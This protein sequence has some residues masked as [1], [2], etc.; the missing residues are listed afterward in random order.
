EVARAEADAAN[1]M[2]DQ[3]LA[4]LSH[5][6]RTPLSAMLGW[7]QMLRKRQVPP[8]R[9]QHALDV[10]HRNT[11]LQA[12]L[13]DDLLDIARVEAGKLHLDKQPVQL[14]PLIEDVIDALQRDVTA[15]QLTLGRHLDPAAG[16]VFGDPTR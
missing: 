1:R 13:I 9:T 16:V 3:F 14:I 11:V 8:E 10:I 12:K 2:K 15:Q 6:L 5:E 4:M 7:V